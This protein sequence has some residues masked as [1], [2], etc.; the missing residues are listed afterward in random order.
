MLQISVS[1]ILNYLERSDM[2]LLSYTL[3]HYIRND[4]RSFK[5][6]ADKHLRTSDLRQ[7]LVFLFFFV[8]ELIR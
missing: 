6:I 8:S 1:P 2:S 4:S 3:F 7:Y 5:V